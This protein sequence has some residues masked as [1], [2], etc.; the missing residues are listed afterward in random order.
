VYAA[1][2][3]QLRGAGEPVARRALEAAARPAAAASLASTTGRLKAA[4][5]SSDAKL[6]HIPQADKDQACTSEPRQVACDWGGACVLLHGAY[7]A[8][9][10][11][12][13]GAL[14]ASRCSYLTVLKARDGLI[15][16]ISSAE[17]VD[18]S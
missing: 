4:A 17:E 13:L 10:V 11:L 3:E 8:L 5:T 1:K 15:L 16:D 6:A 12:Y 2:L 7:F 9:H 18:K 14:V